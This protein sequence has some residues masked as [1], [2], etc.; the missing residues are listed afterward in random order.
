L[1]EGG[2]LLL[3]LPKEAHLLWERGSNGTRVLLPP[4]PKGVLLPFLVTPQNFEEDL[5]MLTEQKTGMKENA[6][7][8]HSLPNTECRSPIGK[9]RRRRSNISPSVGVLFETPFK[10]GCFKKK[11]KGSFLTPWVRKRKSH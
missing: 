5:L 8:E 1:G 9:K 6:W 7:R 10:K 11:G 4:I 2:V 3:L